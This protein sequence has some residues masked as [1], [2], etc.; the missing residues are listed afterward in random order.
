VRS[1]DDVV[2]VNGSSTDGELA[3]VHIFTSDD[4]LQG[5]TVRSYEEGL[6]SEVS[7]FDACNYETT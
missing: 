4:D 6:R 7:K 3:R 2:L 1:N 5:L